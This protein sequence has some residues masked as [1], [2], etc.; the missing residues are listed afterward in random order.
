MSP[1]KKKAKA[2]DVN[3][4]ESHY[5]VIQRPHITEKSTMIGEH[6]K[7]VFRVASD[8]TKKQVK[9]AVEALFKV[10]VTKVNT[11]VTEGKQKRFRGNLGKRQ[12]FKKAIVT[13]AEGQSV[14]LSS[15]I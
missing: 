9:S 6:N 10:K 11:I 2:V 5:L 15:S 13:L 7:L 14:D 1:A 12:D 4:K 8:A 3:V